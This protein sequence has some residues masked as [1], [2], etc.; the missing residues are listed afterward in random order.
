MQ[1]CWSQTQLQIV[2][3]VLGNV[4]SVD[5]LVGLF[6]STSSMTWRQAHSWVWANTLWFTTARCRTRLW[7]IKR[8]IRPMKVQVAPWMWTRT[9]PMRD[10]HL[11]FAPAGLRSEKTALRR[12]QELNSRNY[13]SADS[14]IKPEYNL[15]FRQDNLALGVHCIVLGWFSGWRHKFC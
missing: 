5:W 12:Y 15:D 9:A 4:I 8:L 6:K 10:S 11:L 13:C 2:V 1:F 7:A 14:C 3:V